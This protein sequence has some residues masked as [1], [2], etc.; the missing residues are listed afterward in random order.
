[1]NEDAPK[2]PVFENIRCGNCRRNLSDG[3]LM[4]S[5]LDEI[6]MSV[7]CGTCQKFLFIYDPEAQKQLTQMKE[8][9]K[10]VEES[11]SKPKR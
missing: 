8:D 5:K 7:F 9:R 2:V 1:M 6:R 4:K 3:D 11:N 10:R